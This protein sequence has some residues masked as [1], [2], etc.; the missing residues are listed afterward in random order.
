ML[1]YT[2]SGCIEVKWFAKIKRLKSFNHWSK[3][4]P[5]ES[6]NNGGIPVQQTKPFLLLDCFTLHLLSIH[7]DRSYFL[8]QRLAMLFFQ[9]KFIVD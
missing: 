9:L 1:I 7:K 8:L 6:V 2:S 4:L 5:L 3:L